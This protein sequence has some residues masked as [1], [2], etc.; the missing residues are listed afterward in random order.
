MN[1]LAELVPI[2]L[3][4]IAY[5]MD[6][7]ELDLGIWQYQFDGIYTATAILMAATLIQVGIARLQTGKLEKRQLWLLLAVMVFGG[8]TILLRNELFIQWKPTIF[9][10]ALGMVF[11][12]SQFIGEKNLMARTMGSQITVPDAVWTRINYLWSAYFF[13]VGGLNLI[14]AYNFSEETW[15]DYK[16]YSALG[17]TIVLSVVTV[18]MLSPHLKE[19][20]LD[21]SE[22]EH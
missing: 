9:N 4:F 17:F 3:F 2:L 8:A 20:E 18:A 21:K 15:V 1:Q 13:L 12:G 22:L 10:W 16:L 6:G 14:V 7:Y 5:K 19:S 11:L